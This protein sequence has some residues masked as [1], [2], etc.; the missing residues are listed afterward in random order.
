MYQKIAQLLMY[1]DL[2]E[3]SILYRLGRILEELENGG[4]SVVEVT[5]KVHA[6]SK[7]LLMVATDYGF[8]DNLWHN[9]LAFY[10][11]MNENPFSLVSEKVGAGEGT[12]NTL[13][14]QD[15]GILKELFDYDFSAI[16][17][18]LG[19]NCFTLFSNYKSIKKK[20]LMYNRN[21][22]E[23][24][25]NLSKALEAAPDAHAFFQVVTDFQQE[26]QQGEPVPAVTGPHGAVPARPEEMQVFT[27]AEL[28][29]GGKACE[30]IGKDLLDG[31]DAFHP[32]ALQHVRIVQGKQLPLLAARD[33]RADIMDD[34]GVPQE[35]D[36]VLQLAIPEAGQLLHRMAHGGVGLR[37]RRLVLPQALLIAFEIILPPEAE[38]LMRLGTIAYQHHSAVEI[39][40]LPGGV[41]V[42]PAAQV[43]GCGPV[44]VVREAAVEVGD[45]R[46]R[47]GDRINRVERPLDQGVRVDIKEIPLQE[48]TH[49][50]LQEAGPLHRR[51]GRV[52]LDG[53]DAVEEAAELLRPPAACGK[54]RVGRRVGQQ[55]HP[56][57]RVRPPGAACGHERL[58][59]IIALRPADQNIYQLGQHRTQI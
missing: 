46:Q 53:N 18:K 3:D 47:P 40:L 34:I 37:E 58:L 41:E 45:G 51:E 2:Q 21:V 49:P 26:F 33:I 6:L 20:E 36:A 11:I 13:V 27:G 22:S 55:D 38:E 10:I 14:E 12:V 8:D 1:G 15:F 48:G 29:A 35:T 28:A 30:R 59:E 19:I 23:K 39:D 50:G 44:R 31:G 9:Y 5:R 24:V 52:Q 16:E 54:R 57:G 32:H 7:E 43:D 56:G 4:Y 25:R 17:E 42:R